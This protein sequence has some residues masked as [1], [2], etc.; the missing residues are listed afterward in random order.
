M[1]VFSRLGKDAILK[2]QN[3]L[4]FFQQI[5]SIIGTP[6][7]FKPKLQDTYENN[8][9]EFLQDAR[10]EAMALMKNKSN[11]METREY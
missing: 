3:D 1:A 10:I 7:E 8:I 5:L 4:Q 6:K 2:H 11:N 9:E